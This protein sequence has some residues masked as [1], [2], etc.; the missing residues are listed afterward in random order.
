MLGFKPNIY[1]CFYAQLCI[2]FQMTPLFLTLERPCTVVG[3][4]DFQ[5]VSSLGTTPQTNMLCGF[6]LYIQYI[7]LIIFQAEAGESTAYFSKQ[8]RFLRVRYVYPF[9]TCELC[10]YHV[11]NTILGTGNVAMNKL[12]TFCCFCEIYFS[13]KKIYAISLTKSL[14]ANQ[15]TH[16]LL[17]NRQYKIQK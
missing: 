13:G 16:S 7:M 2:S 3:S 17:N 10:T 12:D 8:I 6:G 15:L 9:N 1:S 5:F 14:M 4:Q 11:P